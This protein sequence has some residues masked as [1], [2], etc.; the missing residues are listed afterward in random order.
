MGVP[1]TVAERGADPI[2]EP[3]CYLREV[4]PAH[5]VVVGKRKISGTAQH[6]T[7]EAVVQH[8]SI[9]YAR[10]TERHLG[11]FAADLDPAD[12]EDRAT[13]IREEARRDEAGDGEG[14]TGVSREAAV[15]SL[16]AML[17][18]W[19]DGEAGTWT[20]DELERAREIGAERFGT[21]AWTRRR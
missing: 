17:R 14:R 7:R 12:F 20:A 4:H 6:R 11:C 15:A 16:E 18:E 10:A 9:T 1:A 5:D 3:A 13:S 2:H 19:A 21:D 8:G